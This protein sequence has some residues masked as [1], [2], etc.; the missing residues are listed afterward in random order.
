MYKW[1]IFNY[2]FKYDDY[3]II[4]N[5][6]NGALI[7]ITNNDLAKIN[8]ILN[9][10]ECIN[11]NYNEIFNEL[12]SQDIIVKETIDEKTF[13]INKLKEDY[14]NDDLISIVI[15]T[16][17]QCNFSCS[18]CYESGINRKLSF[19]DKSITSI[20]S[21][22]DDYLEQN[23]C[24]KR[25]K[26]TLFGGEPTLNWKFTKKI[27]PALD[28]IFKKKGILYKFAIT[29]NGY[30][31][32]EEKIIFLSNYNL[33]SA[34]ITLDGPKDIH[35]KRRVLINSHP[36]FN[37]IWKNISYVLDNNFLNKI[38]LRININNDNFEFIEDLLIFITSKYP[39]EKFD[40][41]LGLI[42]D[43]LHDTAAHKEIVKSI[44][45]ED[46]WPNVYLKLYNLLIKYNF[47]HTDFYTLDGYCL[48]KE[49]YSLII[50]PDNKIY[51][52]LSMIGRTECAVDE[53]LN[54][55]FNI[56]SFLSFKNIKT[57]LDK[58][59]PLVP[60]CLSGCAFEAY[61]DS[62]DSTKINCRKKE[63]DCINKGISEELYA[64]I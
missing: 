4:R 1:S 17:Y 47:K 53:L 37:T 35:D 24:I 20:T 46:L 11:N 57:C 5:M 36:T 23:N 9:K 60:A 29:T 40:I 50:C 27:L 16:T 13:Y 3:S 48:A 45:N 63:Y 22:L 25:A 39:P 61:I 58:G 6:Y 56:K 64:K 44:L 32:N 54:P 28:E 7:K 18:Y 43:T 31:L 41:S 19:D 34:E 2:I 10:S 30:L 33:T 42:T 62:N 8:D 26:V 59:C 52:C 14:D 51:R 21:Y 15:A 38:N 12:L 49:K 55:H